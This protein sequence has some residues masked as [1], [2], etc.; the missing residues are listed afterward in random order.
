MKPTRNRNRIRIIVISAFVLVYAVTMVMATWMT[1]GEAEKRFDT[2]LER[3]AGDIENGIRIDWKYQETIEAGLNGGESGTNSAGG[4]GI[5]RNRAKQEAV[6]R[7]ILSST[8]S[9]SGTEHMLVSAAIYDESGEL[10]TQCGNVLEAYAGEYYGR[11]NW[12]LSDY[13]SREELEELAEYKRKNN[14]LMEDVSAGWGSSSRGG[15]WYEIRAVMTSE[16]RELAEI[17]VT[18][19]PINTFDNASAEETVWTW[20]NPD[21]TA[22]EG[23]R[24]WAERDPYVDSGM[25]NLY[26]PGIWDG[27]NTWRQWQ[28]SSYLQEFPGQVDT[29]ELY[30]TEGMSLMTDQGIADWKAA[31]Q[32]EDETGTSID[33]VYTL[34]LRA[35]AHPW[36]AAA[37]RLKMIYLWGALLTAACA[38]AVL[39]VLEKN[40]REK[41]LLEER[42]RDFVNVMAHEM[43]TPLAVIRG[44]AENLEENVKEEKREYYLH[45]IVNQTE[46]M[47]DIVKELVYISELDD[48]GFAVSKESAAVGEILGAETER[49]APMIEAKRVELNIRTAEE[50][51]V[52]GERRLLEKAFGSLL[53]NAVEYNRDEGRVN[54]T[55]EK[56][57]CVIENTGEEIP[58]EEL[59]RV[60]ELF[61]TGSK[62]K[63][64]GEKHLGIGLYLADRIFKAHGLSLKVEN[65]EEGVRVTVENT[66]PEKQGM[67]L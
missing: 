55:L 17:Y 30:H 1:R 45:Q 36:M 60:C 5:N 4:G 6:M 50:F 54:V 57:R 31:I 18:S 43:K 13:L 63:S 34:F 27:E 19:E 64:T 59:G 62:G 51:E 21:V 37:D 20:K 28:E 40:M 44:F 26:L 42:R 47:D 53:T 2:E 46:K 39:A 22:E 52:S 49:L 33:S 58:E 65:T 35:E 38:A 7:R 29:R 3:L 25:L 23:D 11:I 12:D 8:L 10:V 48:E 32:I 61:Y 16:E 56:N 66:V 9:E 15:Q 67:P 14:E 41:A 24:R